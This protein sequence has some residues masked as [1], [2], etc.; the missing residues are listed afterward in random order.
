MS[1]ARHEPGKRTTKKSFDHFLNRLLAVKILNYAGRKYMRV[2][3]VARTV[4]RF[5]KR[6]NQIIRRKIFQHKYYSYDDQTAIN[7]SGF[8]ES[9]RFSSASG[10]AASVYF[11]N[12]L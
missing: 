6:R 1:N 9:Y 12:L 4:E 10:R 8:K 11:L 7:V 2:R 5:P 3:N